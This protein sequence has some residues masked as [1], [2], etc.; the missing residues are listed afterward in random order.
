[1]NDLSQK[2]LLHIIDSL[3]TKEIMVI[4]DLMLDQYIWGT[5]ERIS[6]E[7]PIPVL[8]VEKEEFRPGGAANV[9]INVNHLNC[10]VHPV[11]IIGLDAPGRR[12]Q[13]IFSS[14]GINTDGMISSSSFQTIVKQR[15]IT[16]QQQLLRIDY[17]APA[18]DLGEVQK[19]LLDAVKNKVSEIDCIILSD[20]AKGVLGEKLLSGIIRLAHKHRIP[21]I[22]DPGKGIDYSWYRGITSI[23]P[24]RLETE[25][26][27]GIKLGSSDS[28]LTAAETLKQSCQAGFVTISLDKDG[29]LYYGSRSDYQ[30]IETKV[31]EVYDVTGAGDTLI[32]TMAA[33]LANGTPPL[34]AT[35]IANTAAGIETSHLGVVPIPWSEI[36]RNIAEDGISKKITTL[37]MLKEEI[38]MN[39]TPLI[40]TNGFFDNIS[41]GHLRFLLEISKFPGKLVVAINSDKCI[42]R[43]K[44]SFPILRETD[45]ARMLASIEN[46]HHIIVFSDDDASHLIRSLHPDIVVKGETFRGTEIPEQKAIEEVGAKIEYIPHFDWSSDNS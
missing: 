18:T 5:V 21:I 15:A 40:F 32:S 28:I 46:V 34:Q 11:G 22:C 31:P 42:K 44:G 26:A 13:E 24:N 30:F 25:Q 2:N 33:L 7:G 8:L 29:I 16:H 39:D 14:Q 1:M 20:Y 35:Y 27:T 41:A 38:R 43:L 12:M 19:R 45:R 23:K 9:A 37:E 3:Q 6:P 4:G 36:R 17:E 10:R